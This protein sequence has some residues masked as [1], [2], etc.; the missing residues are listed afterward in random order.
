MHEGEARDI[1]RQVAEQDDD[2]RA[3]IAGRRLMY[4]GS[5]VSTVAFYAGPDYVVRVT[6]T[7]HNDCEVINDLFET[8]RG[9]HVGWPRIYDVVN[10]DDN[11]CVA[12]VERV[13]TFSTD[14]S[15]RDRLRMAAVINRVADIYDYGLPEPDRDEVQWDDTQWDWYEELL[16]GL[17]AIDD[18]RDEGDHLDASG[19]NV[20]MTKSGRAVWI[21]FGL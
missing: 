18:D 8:N 3:Y 16:Q 13:K 5:G 17:T 7:Q 11:L 15:S 14:M 20:G 6:D 1:I 12:V 2:F 9:A 10:I 19:N 4:A 21:D